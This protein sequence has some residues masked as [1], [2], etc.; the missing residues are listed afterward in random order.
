MKQ[1]HITFPCGGLKLEGIYY[2]VEGETGVSAVVVCHPHPLYGGSMQNNVIYAVAGALAAKAI[3]ALIFNFRGVGE[4]EGRHGGGIDEQQDVKSALD[5]LEIQP[6]VDRGK[7]G[8]AGYSFGAAVALPVA[9]LDG[10][11]RG[12][13]FISPYLEQ[14]HVSLLKSYRKPKLLVSG[15]R[16]NMVLPDDVAA[17]YSEAAEPKKFETINGSDHFWGGYE[18]EMADVVAEFFAGLFK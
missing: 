11:V 2:E 10:R 13:A 6:G 15:S 18:D 5:W 9:C 7:L 1:S 12:A 4:S 16:D 3:A 8:L 14:S 17:Y